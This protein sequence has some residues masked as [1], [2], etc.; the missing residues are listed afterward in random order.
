MVLKSFNKYRKGLKPF[1]KKYKKR[2]L[3]L[4]TIYIIALQIASYKPKPS[5]SNRKNDFEIEYPEVHKLRGGESNFIPNNLFETEPSSSV[6]RIRRCV[7]NLNRQRLFNKLAANMIYKSSVQNYKDES[8]NKKVEFWFR[9][10][11]AEAK[12]QIKDPNVQRRLV[13]E[14]IK[15]LAE[16]WFINKYENIETIS[17]FPNPIQDQSFVK[18]SV[19]L[20]KNVTNL[21]KNNNKGWFMFA[22]GFVLD[23]IANLGG[24]Y[25]KLKLAKNEAKLDS[26]NSSIVN[27]RRIGK[28]YTMPNDMRVLGSY[29]LL[30][31]IGHWKDFKDIATPKEREI[32]TCEN[33]TSDELSESFANILWRFLYNETTSGKKINVNFHEQELVNVYYNPTTRQITIFE[34]R[35]IENYISAYTL[36]NNI[37]YENFLYNNTLGKSAT[38]LANI[39]NQTLIRKSQKKAAA[40]LEEER[41]RWV[42]RAM[43]ETNPSLLLRNYQIRDVEEKINKDPN[44]ILKVAQHKKVKQQFTEIFDKIIDENGD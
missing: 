11:S 23:N 38:D 7:N 13:I 39:A 10:V 25:S 30:T 35:L 9:V 27:K 21:D 1:F 28:Q 41:S 34:A 40:L 31:K 15:L 29:Q 20:S 5:I 18:T 32:L 19:P 43:K 26:F 12:D 44:A 36:K 42:F 3:G 8:Y 24:K 4:I 6:G 16:W 22:D 2:A 37:T 17:S 33:S 14:A